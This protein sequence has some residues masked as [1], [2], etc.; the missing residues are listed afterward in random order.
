NVL[1][2]GEMGLAVILL[3][4]AGLLIESF[5]K[6]LR[7]DPGFRTEHVT[8]FEVTLPDNKYP[9]DRDKRRF[10]DALTAQLA[11]LPGTRDVAT[12][13]NRPLERRAMR[14]SFTITGRPVA[15][16]ERPPVADILPVS[17]SYFS[18]FGIKLVKGRMYDARESVFGV[19][20]VLVVNEAFVKKN[21][22]HE[23]AIGK[24]IVLGITHD[25]AQAD[26]TPVRSEGDIVGVVADVKQ[27]GLK[28]D[29][30]PSVYVP[31]GTLPLEDMSIVVR[32]DADV[33]ALS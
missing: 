18:T 19:P 27:W 16:N 23:D 17:A 14:T 26:K 6:L 32:S 9:F 31:W 4:G 21:F 30:M 8:S 1:V 20:P 25:T 12:S 33:G 28:E 29:A 11:G 22:P 7:V 24:H 10:A 2:V 5:V 15:P 13:F 3:V